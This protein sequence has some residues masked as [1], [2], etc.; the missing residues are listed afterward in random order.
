[1]SDK[2]TV[3]QPLNKSPFAEENTSLLC[4][5]EAVTGPSSKIH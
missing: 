1:M 4:S 2:L 5:P 3:F